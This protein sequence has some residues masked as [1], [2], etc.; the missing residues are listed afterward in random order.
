M[1]MG[2]KNLREQKAWYSI[3]L[4]MKKLFENETNLILFQKTIKIY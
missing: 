4:L 3:R 2:Y 1:R